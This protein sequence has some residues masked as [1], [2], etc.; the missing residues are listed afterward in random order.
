MLVGLL[1]MSDIA[2]IPAG[3]RIAVASRRVVGARMG[4]HVAW[5]P[6]GAVDPVNGLLAALLLG[7][8]GAEM[9]GR[10]KPA[11]PPAAPPAKEY[12]S[13]EFETPAMRAAV[14]GFASGLGP[15]GGQGAAT[16]VAAP[17]APPAPAPTPAPPRE[18]VDEGEELERAVARL[19]ADDPGQAIQ[20]L[21]RLLRRAY[22]VELVNY[23]LAVAY[24]AHRQP[25]ELRATMQRLKTDGLPVEGKTLA[26]LIATQGPLP[27]AVVRSLSLQMLAALDYCHQ[28]RIV[29]RDIKPA[30]VLVLDASPLKIID[31][32]LVRS[33]M[34]SSI[35]VEGTVMGTPPYMPPEQLAG[36]EV[37][38]TA[39]L[40]SFGVVLYEMATGTLPFPPGDTMIRSIATGRYARASSLRPEL[41]AALDRVLARL[42]NR[43]RKERPVRAANV[44]EALAQVL[45]G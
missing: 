40:Y 13:P 30:N 39:D 7:W 17:P 19:D 14:G 15:G 6:R 38:E 26:K 20:V 43:D 1:I 34:S 10:R 3:P 36:D 16:V 44:A 21:E 33:A 18:P 5:L 35:T 2:G 45:P 28:R 31:F 25:E 8:I 22:Q 9:A 41:P 37:D 24:A 4:A 23:Y 11:P 29:H 42:V 12:F 32:G 27:L